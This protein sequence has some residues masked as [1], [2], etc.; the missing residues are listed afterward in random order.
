MYYNKAQEYMTEI[1]ITR[2]RAQEYE[3]SKEL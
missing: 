1:C 2:L 3:T